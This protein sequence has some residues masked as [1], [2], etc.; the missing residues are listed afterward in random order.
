MALKN[1][2]SIDR[3][4]MLVSTGLM[5]VS[6]VVLGLLEILDGAPFGAAPVTNDAGDVVATPLVSPDIRTGLFVLGLIVLLLWAI[7]KMAQPVAGQE[8][9]ASTET[10]AH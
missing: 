5:F 4:V 1:M 7:Y 3:T 8:D 2:D 6:V 9:V 10:P